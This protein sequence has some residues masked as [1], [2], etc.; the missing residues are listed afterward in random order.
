MSVL[1]REYGKEQP[2]IGCGMFKIRLPFIHFR[3]TGPEAITGLCNSVTSLAAIA[4]LVGILGI[5][6]RQ[7]WAVI[8]FSC[9]AYCLHWL[10]GDATVGGW[11]TPAPALVIVFLNGYGEGIPRM[12]AMGALQIELGVL[13]IVLG[14]TGCARK[15]TGMVPPSIKA[16]IVMGTAVTAAF[17][18]FKEGAGL[19]TYP[20]TIFA[21]SMVVFYFMFSTYFKKHSERIHLFRIMGR[22]AFACGVFVCLLVGA[23]TG[24]IDYSMVSFTQILATPD[25]AGAIRSM[26]PFYIGFAPAATWF[27]ALPIAFVA[28]IIAFGDFITV[29]QLGMDAAREDELVDYN[30]N[31][32]NVVCGLRNLFL[33]LLTPFP[34]LGGPMSAP[35]AVST[36]QRYKNSGREG[37]DS[38]WDGYGTNMILAVIGLFCYPLYLVALAGSGAVLA[39]L[40]MI[41]GYVCT[42]IAV[43]L[44]GDKTDLGIAGMMSG[45]MV[46]RG[47]AWGIGI[48]ILLY[49][50]LCGPE[51]IRQDYQF[52]LQKQKEEDEVLQ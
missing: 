33:G 11:I 10:L 12:Q 27:Q 15:I 23:V 43:S 31:R 6:N 47:G 41:Q 25:F 34:P 46:A 38:I 9:L 50:L 30:T 51:K 49:F 4:T 18:Q 17:S 20:I 16:G 8:V 28:Y 3:F 24:E 39:V 5:E 7:A 2:Y 29:K 52:N 19:Y 26:S 42:Q 35:Y 37:M 14:V 48:G 45:V 40:V 36:F 13:F 32:T 1:K 44:A 22:F 21:G